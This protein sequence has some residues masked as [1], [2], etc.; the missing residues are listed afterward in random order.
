[1]IYKNK[2]KIKYIKI[3]FSL[4]E[5]DGIYMPLRCANYAT[6]TRVNNKERKV[7]K[8][9]LLTQYINELDTVHFHIDKCYCQYD[10]G[11]APEGRIIGAYYKIKENNIFFN[12]SSKLFA[13]ATCLGAITKNNFEE[14][15][16]IIEKSFGITINAG[17]LCEKVPLG[18]VDVK[19]D[20]IMDYNPCYYISSLRNLFKRATSEFDVGKCYKLTYEN[21]F[22][23]TPKA[24]KKYRYSIYNKGEELLK[25]VNKPFRSMF[26]YDYLETLDCCLRAEVQFTGFEMI[27]NAFHLG[28]R[29]ETTFANILAKDVD[30][31][32]EQLSELFI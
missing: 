15:A 4:N 27:R 12:I 20:R 25:A 3:S 6:K 19:K 5:K 28:K 17:Y 26:N 23:I 16:K 1:M 10:K 18:R 7:I 14:I 32:G 21:G 24:Q 2:N 9:A 13:T 8:M 30:V 29:E 11:I 22:N 31:L